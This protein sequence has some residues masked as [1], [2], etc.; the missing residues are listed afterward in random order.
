MSGVAWNKVINDV[1]D[2]WACIHAKG[3]RFEH[4]IF[5]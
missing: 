3:G 5:Q 2:E 4:L 1:M